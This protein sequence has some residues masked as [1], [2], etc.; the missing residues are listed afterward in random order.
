MR[1][2]RRWHYVRQSD[3]VKKTGDQEAVLAARIVKRFRAY[4][5]GAFTVYRPGWAA[6][7]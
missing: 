4:R 3:A 2:R 5:R 6:G 1:S 7:S